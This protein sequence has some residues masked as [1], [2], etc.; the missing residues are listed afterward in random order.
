MLHKDLSEGNVLIT[1]S[2]EVGKRAVII[3]FDYAKML[4]DPSLM[5]DPISVCYCLPYFCRACGSRSCRGHVRLYPAR[6][7]DERVILKRTIQPS[8]TMMMMTA[9]ATATQTL[10]RSEPS[11]PRIRSGMTWRVS[12][13]FSFGCACAERALLCNVLKYG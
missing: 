12:S 6:Y 11:H 1:G 2:T 9:T 4:E 8:T 7:S 5:D 13:G 10:R 3:D